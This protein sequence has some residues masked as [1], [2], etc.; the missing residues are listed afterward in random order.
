MPLLQVC[1]QPETDKIENLFGKVFVGMN[2][3]GHDE[4]D[5]RDN[6]NRYLLRLLAARPIATRKLLNTRRR[7]TYSDSIG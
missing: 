6:G 1:G 3:F 4:R 2:N 5:K 7:R